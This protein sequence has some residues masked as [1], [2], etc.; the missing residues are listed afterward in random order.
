MQKLAEL[1]EF[2]EGDWTKFLPKS[3]L[4]ERDETIVNECRNKNVLHVGAADSP[5]EVEKGLAGVLLHQKI[6]KVT[7]RLVGVDVDE[8]AVSAL[9]SVGI[10]DVIVADICKDTVLSGEKFDV[11]LCCDVI[12]HVTSPGALL[13][14]CK[15]F[16]RSDSKL[17]VSTI[18][19][20][21]LKPVIRALAG[22]ESVHHDH[23]AYY[24]FATLGKLLTIH[25]LK[26]TEFGVFAYPTLK[27]WTGWLSR[28]IMSV[29]PGCADGILFNAYKD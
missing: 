29:A 18:N 2:R 13:D 3:C 8:A 4:I 19:A 5:F 10:D 9:R 21:A 23:V 24:S 28:Q 17:V 12:E 25:G 6:Q 27:P 11:I 22:R 16:M 1:A 20:T 15:R 7:G 26:P 14:A